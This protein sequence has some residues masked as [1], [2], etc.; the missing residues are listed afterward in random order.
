MSE[1]TPP[2]A[3]R[4][5][6]LVD[7]LLDSVQTGQDFVVTQAPDVVRE[8]VLWNQVFWGT[9]TGVLLIFGLALVWASWKC[10]HPKGWLAGDWERLDEDKKADGVV[11]FSVITSVVTCFELAITANVLCILA[12]WCIAPKLCVLEHV[13]AMMK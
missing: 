5:N 4:L 10:W 1:P 13:M 2:E 7:W 12:K 9:A 11:V 6:E 3:D 8:L